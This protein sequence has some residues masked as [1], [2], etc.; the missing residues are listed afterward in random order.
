MPSP[1]AHGVRHPSVVGQ[2]EE[3]ILRALARYHYLTAEQFTRLLY[4]TKVIK[5]VRER[6]KH[7]AEADLVQRIVMRRSGRAGGAAYA[8]RLGSKGRTYLQ[9]LGLEV[10]ARYRPSEQPLDPFL[11]HTLAVN[12]VLIAIELLTR[13]HPAVELGTMLHER[14]LKQQPVT[15][16]QSGGRAQAVIPDGWVALH[17]SNAEGVF[18]ECFAL[19]LDRGHYEQRRWRRKVAALLD[20][21]HGTYQEAFGTSA[22]TIM[23]AAAPAPMPLGARPA[24]LLGER[25]RAEL[26]RWTEAE[27]ADC[28]KTD[29][30]DLFRFTGVAADQVSPADFL[31]APVWHRPFDQEVRPLLDLGVHGY[32]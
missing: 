18:E 29:A 2:P 21:T 13:S 23:V 1:V 4:G 3:A 12:D 26:L 6:L 7:M 9:A 28:G 17:I 11:E 15:I 16:K 31:L 22:L 25:R 8:Y 10:T 5:Y 30:A 20:W 24:E 19:E 27:L 14:V 32:G